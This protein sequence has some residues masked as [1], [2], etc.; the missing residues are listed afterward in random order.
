MPIRNRV[1]TPKTI[2]LKPA[3]LRS[4]GVAP[5]HF[6]RVMAQPELFQPD[7]VAIER[8]RESLRRG[9]PIA[10]IKLVELPADP[11]AAAGLLAG[12]GGQPTPLPGMAPLAAYRFMITD[13][14]DRAL[15]AIQEDVPIQGEF[16]DAGE[17]SLPGFAPAAAGVAVALDVISDEFEAQGK[18]LGSYRIGHFRAIS[19]LDDEAFAKR[20]GIP[21]DRVKRASSLH[22][23]AQDYGIDPDRSG[24]TD[25]GLARARAIFMRG[26]RGGG[27]GAPYPMLDLRIQVAK[28]VFAA[29]G[30][31]GYAL[32]RL[33]GADGRRVNL[34]PVSVTTMENVASKA[35][36]AIV[37]LEAHQS[38]LAAKGQSAPLLAEPA[39]IA[40]FAVKEGMWKSLN[41]QP[42][43]IDITRRGGIPYEIFE[44]VAKLDKAQ[45]E[46]LLRVYNESGTLQE[47]DLS[48]AQARSRRERNRVGG[49]SAVVAPAEAGTGAASTGGMEVVKVLKVGPMTVAKNILRHMP[50][51]PLDFTEVEFLALG[52]G[53][54]LIRRRP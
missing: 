41:V 16:L 45:Q 43:W 50:G 28:E 1:N 26:A 35:M 52:D 24:L 4:L 21:A 46:D 42:A 25:M 13:G 49:L 2:L 37:G 17:P 12:M 36:Q 23:L 7:T 15:A 10:A 9:R 47:T 51:G 48:R 11:E 40:Q 22:R 54:I 3:D 6:S 20:T 8:H 27:D 14:L 30:R 31:E 33:T 34:A 39:D 29:L 32:L 38:E 5:T 18:D 19:G 53:S 44:R